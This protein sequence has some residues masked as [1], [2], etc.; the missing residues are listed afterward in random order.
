V[1]SKLANLKAVML[2]A[3]RWVLEL[4]MLAV[5]SGIVYLPLV[6]KL[7]LYLDDW[8]LVFIGQTQGIQKFWN[9]YIVD[10]PLRALLVGFFYLLFGD[11]A[12]WYHISAWL[13]H[14]A[15]A[16]ILLWILRILW[17]RQRLAI[18]LMALLFLVYPGFLDQVN[19]FDYQS[20]LVSLFFYLLSI[21]LSLH[22]ITL[23]KSLAKA[24]IFLLSILLALVALGLMEYYIGLEGLR[25]LAIGLLVL[26]SSQGRFRQKII[27]VVLQWLPFT[28][29]PGLFLAWR[30]VFFESS[31]HATNI[32]SMMGG[33]ASSPAL[34]IPWMVVRLV[35]DLLNTYLFAFSVPAYQ[36][37]FQLRLRDSLLGF[38][39]A[40]LA[41]GVMLSGLVLIQSENQDGK[42]N[43]AN[44]GDWRIEAVILGIGMSAV[45]LFPVHFGDRHVSF[46]GYSRFTWTPSIGAVMVLVALLFYIANPRVRL[47]L[48]SLLIVLAAFTHFGNAT[49]AAQETETLRQF[50]WQVTWRAPD[51]QEGATLI[52]SYP[53]AGLSEDY[54]IWGPAN[55]IYYPQKKPVIPTIVSLPAEIINEDIVLKIISGK[56]KEKT[57]SRGLD[58]TKDFSNI[59]LLS[60]PSAGSCV[61]VIDGRHVELSSKERNDFM[62]VAS[63][64]R[65]D[66]VIT[67]GTSPTPPGEIFGPEPAHTW[68]YFY[69][70][71]QIARQRGD[72]KEV[73][74]LGDE[75]IAQHLNPDDWVEWLVFLQGYAQLGQED[76]VRSLAPTINEDR[77]LKKQVCDGLS[78]EQSYY[79]SLSYESRSLMEELFCH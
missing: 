62:L 31:R 6:G 28:S 45:A 49:R 19:A 13:F 58:V 21:A 70:K 40:A 52:A 10:R 29:A 38:F 61:Q 73:T 69:E 79:A 27:R 53:A 66:N 48:Y 71:A 12:L 51:I 56:G 78:D 59:L 76:R 7:G 68:C 16:G 9:V 4:L 36:G 41:V 72:W 77:F 50:W 15:A 65:L 67:E 1:A 33:I 11:R 46:S 20:H 14:L 5:V 34:R 26:R 57:I 3:P 23:K 64:S 24:G 35:Q 2:R 32:S 42:A 44:L 60:M 55:L 54:V 63:Y 43:H 30:M 25:F 37:F 18:L 8:Y 17:P 74:W 47:S 75:A 39:L 22:W